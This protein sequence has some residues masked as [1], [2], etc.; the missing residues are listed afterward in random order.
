MTIR[1]KLLLGLTP[2]LLLI[3]AG[4]LLAY[5]ALQTVVGRKE[6]VERV[7]RQHDA[8]E[9]L[10]LAVQQAIMPPNDYLITGDPA[11]R[12]RFATLAADADKAYTTVEALIGDTEEGRTLL[13]DTRGQWQQ[14]RAL[15]TPRLPS[16]APPPVACPRRCRP[17]TPSRE[18]AAAR[19]WPYEGS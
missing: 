9:E 17:R 2:G 13:A 8:V 3:L 11:E 12:A 7:F 14:A 6:G 5:G 1:K 19:L 10:Q 4:G 18:A 16:P 15:M